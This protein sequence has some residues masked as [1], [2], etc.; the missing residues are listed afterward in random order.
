FTGASRRFDVAGTVAGVTVVD[1][2]AHHPREVAATIDA[3][4]GIVQAQERPGRVLAVLQPHLFSRTRDF[5]GDFAEA[6]SAADHAWVLPIYAAREDPDPTVTART[7]TDLAAPG[8]VPVEDEAQL[9]ALVSAH[10]RPG[11]LLL[12]LGAGDI[13]ELTPALMTVLDAP[14]DRA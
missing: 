7:I 12:M 8:V 4:R 2:Y 3:A 9:A 14:G 5:A 6:L 1:D 13:V 10:A 11:D